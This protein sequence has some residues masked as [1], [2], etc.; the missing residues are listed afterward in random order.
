MLISSRIGESKKICRV[1]MI[2]L[3]TM[4]L[5]AGVVGAAFGQTTTAALNGTIT[6]AKGAA[7][8]GVTV[9]IHSDDT[10]LDTLEKTND[11]GFY[12]D[13]LLQPGTYDVTAAQPGFATVQSKNV[14]LQVGQTVGLDFQMP[15]AAQQSLVTVTTEAPLIETE[16]TEQSQ[17]ISE[18]LVSNLPTGSRRW[19]QFVLLTP[20]ITPDGPTGLMSFHG[21]NSMYNNNSVDG[22]N[23][24]NQYGGGVRGGTGDGYVYSSDAI[25]E[26]QVAS[27]N[28]SAEFGQ[29]AGGAVNAI[30]KSGT[31]QFHGDAFYS[32]R[33]AEFNALDP[34]VKDQAATATPGTS[35]ATPTQTVHQQNQWGASIGGPL[36]KDKLF[37]FASD[38][39]YRKVSID[40]VGT[41][42]PNFPS[43]SLTGCPTVASFTDGGAGAL[44][45]GGTLTQATMNA[46]CGAA[47][48]FINSV[49]LGNFP[50]FLRQDIEL[51]KLDYQLNASNHLNVVTNI[52]DWS[53]PTFVTQSAAGSQAQERFVIATW[54][55]VIGTDKVNELRYQW[56]VDHTKTT[57]ND[58][59]PAVTLGNAGTLTY[60][61]SGA[62]YPAGNT[63]KRNQVSDNFSLTKGAHQF[64]FGVDLNFV[65][66]NVN[67]SNTLNGSYTY[68][69]VAVAGCPA[70][71]ATEEYCDWILDLFG[72]NTG[73]GK[74]GQHWT[75]FSQFVDQR[76]ALNALST[77]AGSD[78][79]S[80][81]DYAGYFQD[82]WKAKPNL[83]LSLG[84]RYD[85]QQLPPEPNPNNQLPILSLYTDSAP[86]DFTGGIQPRLGFA[87][88]LAKGTVL[89]GGLG[90]FDS[91]ISVSG[92]SSAHRTSGTREQSF[93][94]SPTTSAAPCNIPDADEQTGLLFPDVLY[95][96]E[97]PQLAPFTAAGLPANEQPLVP[98]VVASPFN[99]CVPPT[100]TCNV[101]GLNPLL[102]TPRAYEGELALERQ[103][104]GQ[105]SLTASWIWTRGV[106]L[107]QY[108]DEN[109]APTT[110]TKS[111]DIVN[112]TGVTQLVSTVPF[113]GG[114]NPA[115]GNGR[116]V[117]ATGGILA[118][119]STVNSMYN[120]LVLTLRKPISHGFEILANYTYSHSDDDGEASYNGDVGPAGETF[121]TGAGY[122]DPYN[123]KTEQAL[124]GTDVPNRF[125]ASVVYAPTYANN[126]SNKIAKNALAGWDASATITE[127]DGTRYT[128]FVQGTGQEC[129]VG[130][131]PTGS[132]CAAQGGIT[133][134]DGGMTGAIL[135]TSATPVGGRVAWLPRDSFALPA[136]SDIDFRIEKNFSIKERYHIAIRGE[137]FNLFNT[138][139]IQSVNE[140]AY[141]YANPGAA[142]C[143]SI[144]QNPV[145]GHTNTCMVPLST[146]QAVTATTNS[147]GLLG[148]RQLQAGIR[149]EF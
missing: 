96:Q 117:P 56:G 125:T 52:R 6:D 143:P 62:Y 25:R 94:C 84:F 24:N 118:E 22:A 146:F 14:I 30:T 27:N 141:N 121:L 110:A 63:E 99:A 114:A 42:V 88:N 53:Q 142:G 76:F 126:L 129:S 100:A 37:F 85:F 93:T 5:L 69:G 72:V 12:T 57:I 97:L 61:Q 23:N 47:N 82:T 109:I 124:S 21:I 48:N 105:M 77:P 133:A 106:H 41:S 66:D 29:A 123:L 32:G 98:A 45:G 10:G 13:P 60:G 122:L 44:R 38:D 35:A 103:L 102:V 132:S 111:Y 70:S 46:E 33:A 73:D 78:I 40:S 50:R 127:T 68:S 136:Y 128:G 113:Y 80:S 147:S 58:V 67:S 11:S 95:S 104:P 28:Y 108:V 39:N 20:G 51:V 149:F 115:V 9:T 112:T 17:N 64:K 75:T 131:I 137:A 89:R 54:N 71:G 135:Q 139:I 79:F 107:P 16:K 7:M 90:I 101:R 130:V 26:Y 74:T 31:S 144:A 19:E 86:A 138:T 2:G 65:Y 91:E 116:L 36:I 3:A 83:T 4:S 18:D 120:A 145:T 140:F 15:V 8:S 92:L 148:P 43:P 49:V 119:E 55:T 134:L 87:W 1:G 81:V 59:L 34:F